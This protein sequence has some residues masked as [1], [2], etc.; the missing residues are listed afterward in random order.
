MKRVFQVT[1]ILALAPAVAAP[2]ADAGHRHRGSYGSQ[3]SS[4]GESHGS[5]GSSGGSSGNE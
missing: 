1:G 5:Y 4:G 2:S 3:G